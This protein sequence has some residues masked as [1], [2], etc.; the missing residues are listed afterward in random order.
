MKNYKDNNYKNNNKANKWQ[1]KGLQRGRAS[2]RARGSGN[3]EV[4]AAA[5]T[6]NDLCKFAFMLKYRTKSKHNNTNEQQ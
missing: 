5:R 1:K 6:I 4:E 3:G 2:G